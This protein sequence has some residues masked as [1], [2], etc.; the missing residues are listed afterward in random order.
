MFPWWLL[1]LT[2]PG[3]TGNNLEGDGEGIGIVI[4]SPSGTINYNRIA[5]Y[6]YYIQNFLFSNFG[7]SI[8][9]MLKPIDDAIK[10][11]PELEPILKPIRDDLDRLFHKLENSNTSACYNWYGTN[12]PEAAR[13]FPGNGTLNYY[14]WLI[15]NI[16]ATP[17]IIT[18]G[19]TSTITATVYHDAAGGDHSADA[20]LFFRGP[21][22][23]FTTSL[24]N[25]G[26]KSI[27]VPWVNGLAIAVLRADEGPG[28]AVVSASDYQTVQTTVNIRK[29][30]GPSRRTYGA[31]LV[32]METTGAPLAGIIVSILLLLGG[33][34]S[35]RK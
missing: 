6:R 35:A 16:I 15:M 14:P 8:D 34:T 12:S 3:L 20:T 22:V 19:E 5:S 28:T 1:A 11:H 31:S 26:S 25:L 30:P 17:S 18:P 23:T 21:R 29:A 10:K 2:P 7:P 4:C 24:G 33:L 32:G 13:F 9:E 27:T